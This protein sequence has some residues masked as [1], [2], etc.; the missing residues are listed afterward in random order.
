MRESIQGIMCQEKDLFSFRLTVIGLNYAPHTFFLALSFC[1]QSQPNGTLREGLT[2]RHQIINLKMGF[3]LHPVYQYFLWE[4]ES[5]LH[6]RQ[7][8]R[9]ALRFSCLNF[10]FWCEAP[11]FRIAFL[12][13]FISSFSFYFVLLSHDV[14]QT[15]MEHIRYWW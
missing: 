4:M 13:K 10:K 5:G 15:N 3:S 1:R 6:L 7:R 14:Q 12:C 2:I 8:E 9:E 11:T